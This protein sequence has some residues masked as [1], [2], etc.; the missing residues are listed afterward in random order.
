MRGGLSLLKNNLKEKFR[1]SL[2]S[3]IPVV[4]IVIIISFTIVTVSISTI[5]M[6]LVGATLLVVGMALFTLGAEVAMTP[7]GEMVGAH[8]TK[9]RKLPLIVFFGFV[10]GFIITIAEPD[11]QVLAEQ[12]SSISNSVLII[13]VAAGVG[14]FLVVAL[15]RIIF[16]LRL[17][18]M[19][20]G[21][22]LLVAIVACFVPGDFI[23]IAFDSGGVTTGPMTV[24]LILALGVGVASVRSDTDAD[25]DSFGLIALCSLGP[26]IAV[27]ILSMIFNAD[28]EYAAI[29]IPN[30]ESTYELWKYFMDAL[31]VYMN[32][33]TI[34]IAPIFV[35]FIIYQ[36][37]SFRL[38]VRALIKIIAGIIYTL[39][40]LVLFLTGVNVGFI[41][42]GNLLAQQLA[43]LDYNWIIVPIGMLIGY[44]IVSAEPAVY[45]LNKQVE[46]V[47]EGA[48]S[49]KVMKLGLSLG[50]SIS[51]GL[52]MIRVLTGISII[53][54]L[55]PGYM[56]AIGLSFFVPKIFTSIAFDSGGVASGPLSATFLLPFAMG[57]CEALGGNITTDAFGIVAMVAMTP[58]I[59]IQV[60]GLYYKLKH[61]GMEE[62][63]EA[64]VIEE[65]IIE[66]EDQEG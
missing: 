32:E 29:V 63:G 3:V 30:I 2:S 56:I 28:G 42:A 13:A 26:I 61:G 60:I 51:V 24:P 4:A 35:F 39:V 14:V 48:I 20:L 45:V 36:V 34:A 25:D 17:S 65:E 47:T 57:A 12:V 27:M 23:A 18:F 9:T 11:L 49:Q 58:I 44:F 5:M 38:P 15:L 1:E 33:V 53:W 52:S 10:V 6:F 55:I 64:Q 37:V 16:R 7:M 50:V 66:L 21:I 40:G 59:T 22:Y 46:E 8:L 31:P 19:L 62:T 54:Y 43:N 41:P